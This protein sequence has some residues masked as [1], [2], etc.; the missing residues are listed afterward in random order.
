MVSI[1]LVEQI[2]KLNRVDKL[3]LI[4]ILASQLADEENNLIQFGA[5]YEVWSPYDAIEAAHIMLEALQKDKSI[6]HE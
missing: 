1:E 6:N 5:S 2:R 4:Q 3:E